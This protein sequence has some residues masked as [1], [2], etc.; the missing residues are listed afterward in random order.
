MKNKEQTDN[1]MG[2][3]QR[4]KSLATK[5]LIFKALSDKQ[6]HRNMELKA[7]TKLTSRTLAKHLGQMTI[8]GIIERK[9]DTESGKYPVPILY[10]ASQPL[11]DYITSLNIRE[12]F[13]KNVEDMI[14]ETK[15]PLFIL[16][17]IHAN[18]QVWFLQILREMQARK[19]MKALEINFLEETFLFET[20]ETMIRNLIIATDK[21]IDKIDFDQIL[22]SQAKRQKILSEMIIKHF[23]EMGLIKK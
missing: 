11:I 19:D 9:E 6:W 15:D 3:Y 5:R 20:Y 16:E 23:E 8:T 1:G 17:M 14:D 21:I 2:I 22:V 4:Q 18:S 12:T 7:T 13:S 10:K